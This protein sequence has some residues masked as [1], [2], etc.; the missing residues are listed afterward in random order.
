M[1]TGIHEISFDDY[2]KI[3]AMSA[4]ALKALSHSYLSYTALADKPETTSMAFG[5]LAH[6]AV[7]EPEVLDRAVI[8]PE[9]RINEKGKEV[10]FVRAGK[11]WDEFKAAN[12]ENDIFSKADYE[13]AMLLSK[14]VNA[15]PDAKAS[16]IGRH[17]LSLVWN[18]PKFGLSKCRF[19]VINDF[20]GADLKTC[21][22]IDDRGFSSACAAYRY[23]IQAA[24]YMRGAKA[25]G[26]DLKEFRFIAVEPSIPHDNAVYIATD[27]MIQSGVK[28]MKEAFETLKEGPN[29]SWTGAHQGI[30]FIDMPEYFYAESDQEVVL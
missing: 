21:Q 20:F 10:K 30:S 8:T 11:H 16:L 13:S 18:D 4:T 3:D 14:T 25:C 19:D 22:R 28:G 9:Y 5:T 6:T 23:D 24:W 7:L 2:L 26:Y 12:A 29:M 15:N 17:E 1:N 27:M